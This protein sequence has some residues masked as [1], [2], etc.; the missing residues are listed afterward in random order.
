MTWV[1]WGAAVAVP[2]WA[3]C[4]LA[5]VVGL[6]VGSFANVVVFRTP[7]RLSVVRPPSFCPGCSTP[8]RPLDNIPVVSWLMLRGRCRTCG[9]H[10]SVRYPLLEAGTGILFGLVALASGPH[11]SVFGLCALAATLGV[12]AVI[13]IDAQVPPRAVSWVGAALGLAGLAGA[14]GVEHHWIRF[15]GAGIGAAIAFVLSPLLERWSE[16][17][18]RLGSE[19]WWS[20]V[21]AG[22]VLGWSGPIGAATGAGV[23]CIAVLVVP[24]V[25]PAA[26]AGPRTRS[27]GQPSAARRPGK[28]MAGPAVASALAATAA[29][30]AALGA[31]SPLG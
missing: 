11:W 7:R 17:A 5:G 19:A 15:L 10:I 21:P 9:Q 3:T 18:G 1:T 4:G 24:G 22:A 31:G 26:G 8:I 29:V 14:A 6:M 27:A 2:R 23:L 16:T 20:L 28:R 12:A 25:R 13:E 30:I